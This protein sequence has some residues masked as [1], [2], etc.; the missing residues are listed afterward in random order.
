MPGPG[1]GWTVTRSAQEDISCTPCEYC[2]LTT[3]PISANFLK[4][5][6]LDNSALSPNSP[7]VEKLINMLLA[8]LKIVNLVDGKIFQTLLLVSNIVQSFITAGCSNKM[9]KYL[10]ETDFERLTYNVYVNKACNVILRVDI[11]L[12]SLGTVRYGKKVGQCRVFL[13]SQTI[14]G[15]QQLIIKTFISLKSVQ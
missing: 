11:F 2:N 13:T 10:S 1:I 7:S 15:A 3:W 4:I 9:S 8:L 12:P 6:Q 14:K 5:S